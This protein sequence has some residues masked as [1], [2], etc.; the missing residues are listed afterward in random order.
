MHQNSVTLSSIRHT[1]RN[2][3]QQLQNE[4]RLLDFGFSPPPKYKYILYIFVS[5]AVLYKKYH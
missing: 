1:V 5:L 4:T 2:E 3:H